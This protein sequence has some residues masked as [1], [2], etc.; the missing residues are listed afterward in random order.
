MPDGLHDENALIAIAGRGN[1]RR[2]A[3]VFEQEPL[4]VDSLA[5]LRQ[6]RR[7]TAY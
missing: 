3:D 7:S 2:R 1:S 4:S 6:R 5:A